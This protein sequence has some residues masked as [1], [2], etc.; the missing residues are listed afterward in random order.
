MLELTP[1]QAAAA[2]SMSPAEW[3]AHIAR[4]QP[5]DTAEQLRTAAA[6][7]VPADQLDQIMSIVD[8]SK[9][10]GDD[11]AI[12]QARVSEHFGR[13]FG[14]SEPQQPPSWGQQ[15]GGGAPGK[16]LGDDA[17]AALKRRHGVGADTDQPTAGAC[18]RPG[19]KGRAALE[20]RHGRNL[21]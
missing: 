18:I 17:R 6:Q 3:S 16:Q 7:H 19:D 5:P 13:W 11:G 14:P 2:A 20:R 10:V 9:F 1:E 15:S 21:K 4:Y 8:P 12:D